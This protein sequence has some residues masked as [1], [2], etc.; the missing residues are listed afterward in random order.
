MGFDKYKRTYDK[1]MI[2]ES[3]YP[4]VFFLLKKNNIAVGI[5]KANKLLSKLGLIENQLIVIETIIDSQLVSQ[6][7]ILSII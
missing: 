3:S 6:N 4:E 7:N 5:K 1:K 2:K